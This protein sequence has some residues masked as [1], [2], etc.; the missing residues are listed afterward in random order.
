VAV[1][2]PL[3]VNHL[4]LEPPRVAPVASVK[5]VDLVPWRAV[6]SVPHQRNQRLGSVPR[7]RKLPLVSARWP[8]R[9][10]LDSE[11]LPRNLQAASARSRA[12][13]VV[14]SVKRQRLE[15]GSV[16][17]RRRLDLVSK[18][19]ADSVN[20]RAR[21]DLD[22]RLVRADL[23]NRSR[24]RLAASAEEVGSDNPPGSDN[25]V[26]VSG[27]QPVVVSGSRPGSGSLVAV[28]SDR[29]LVSDNR[30]RRAGST[31]QIPRSLK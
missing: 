18:R 11:P 15:V 23:D 1:S 5:A 31:R 17:R 14:G 3:Q 27:S 4:V 8:P 19:R 20:P 12:R 28:V 25:P 13:A 22:S 6:G 26:V 30:S 10:Q 16:K 7:Q 29:H 21:E 2:P 9:R 24:R